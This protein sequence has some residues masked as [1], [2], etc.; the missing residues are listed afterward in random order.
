MPGKN[1][2]DTV[3]EVMPMVV[4]LNGG[5]SSGKSSI[6]RCLQDQLASTWMAL[7]VDDLIRV[8]RR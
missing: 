8:T 1:A 6:A 2:P 4:V 5:S 7:G 3:G